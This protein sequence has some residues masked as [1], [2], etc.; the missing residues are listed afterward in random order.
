VESHVVVRYPALVLQPEPRASARMC[1]LLTAK[2]SLQDLE[3]SFNGSPSYFTAR[4]GISQDCSN[5]S[6][7]EF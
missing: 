6:S 3:S 5:L 7:S 2:R 1:V 4:Y